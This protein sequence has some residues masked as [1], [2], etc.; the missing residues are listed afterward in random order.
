M[1]RSIVLLLTAASLGGCATPQTAP[2]AAPAP[3]PATTMAPA[4]APAGKDP[5]AA[6]RIKPFQYLYGSAEA[7]ALSVQSWHDIVAFARD[8]VAHRPADSV[9]L[10]EGATPDAPRFI[11]CGNRPLAAVFDVDETV[12][13]NL[14]LEEQAAQG[15]PLGG[16]VFD[17]WANTGAN[18]VAPVPGALEGIRAL[19]AMGVEV[20]YNTNRSSRTAEGTAQA[21]EAAGLGKATHLRNLYLSGDDDMGARKDGRRWTISKDYCVIALA[22][23]QLVDISDIF[24]PPG[25][26]VSDRRKMAIQG[27]ISQ[28]WGNGW[29]VLP[30]GTYGSSLR[31]G[32][33]DIF[34]ADKRWTDTGAGK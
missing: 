12:I 29:F 26:S 18:A 8:K 14:G 11:P 4:P 22:G 17:R 27:W 34:P 10:A 30:N 9:V 7:A 19:R 20:I 21:I 15:K 2:V 1:K 23:D 16:G 25:I 3:A 32:I 33:D 5:V 13:L 24:N 28:M 6:E 31:G